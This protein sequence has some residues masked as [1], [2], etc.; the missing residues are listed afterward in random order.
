MLTETSLIPIIL[1][2]S[3]AAFGCLRFLFK[4]LKMIEHDSTGY[5]RKHNIDI[6]ESGSK[7]KTEEQQ[8]LYLKRK[9]LDIKER[10]ENREFIESQIVRNFVSPRTLAKVKTGQNPFDTEVRGLDKA[11]Q[12][13]ID[14]YGTRKEH[15]YRS[16]EQRGKT[17]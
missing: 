3:M 9:V 8:K 15:R 16:R 6:P 2:L 17:N 1:L 5:L 11:I 14:A 12:P 4:E 10:V 13:I 7:I